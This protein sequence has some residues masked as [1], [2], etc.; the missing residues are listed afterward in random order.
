VLTATGLVNGRWQFSAPYRIN[1]P[2]PIAKKFVM[3]DYVGDPYSCAKCGAHPPL[4]ASGQMGEIELKSFLFM[5]LFSGTHLQVRRVGGFS[6]MMA[7]TTWTRARMC[8][9]GASLTLL[10]I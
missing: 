7:Q 8:L 3:G 6:L 10:P 1:T 9:L 4:G 5:T 2:Q